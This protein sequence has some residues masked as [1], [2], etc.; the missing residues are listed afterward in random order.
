MS[1]YNLTAFY[2][3]SFLILSYSIFSRINLQIPMVQ[4]LWFNLPS[5]ENSLL[6]T[7]RENNIKFWS[8]STRE[9]EDWPK[10]DSFY[11][12]WPCV[13][14]C[15]SRMCNCSCL[16]SLYMSGIW[17][18]LEFLVTCFYWYFSSIRH[19]QLQARYDGRNIKVSR[20]SYCLKNSWLYDNGWD[21]LIHHITRTL[22]FRKVVDENRSFNSLAAI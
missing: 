17:D 9:L 2:I 12:V 4:F 19:S 15:V 6:A 14:V 5:R 3:L 22:P 7:S 13:C 21:K 20:Y 1:N 11:R 8:F 16:N 18:S 10:S